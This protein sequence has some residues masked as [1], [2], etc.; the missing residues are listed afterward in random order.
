VT[1]NPDGSPASSDVTAKLS[2]WDEDIPNEWLV[3]ANYCRDINDCVE[4]KGHN[5]LCRGHYAY[6]VTFQRTY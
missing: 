6:E 1:K 4:R 2:S 3:E 5:Q